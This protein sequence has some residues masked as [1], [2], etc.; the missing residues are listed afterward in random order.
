[1]SYK[2]CDYHFN[3][4]YG[5]SNSKY[6]SEYERM[7]LFNTAVQSLWSDMP[8]LYCRVVYYKRTGMLSVNIY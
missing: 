1:M 7:G 6:H 4:I 5:W 3:R 8:R 2:L